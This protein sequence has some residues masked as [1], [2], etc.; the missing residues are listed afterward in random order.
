MIRRPHV[1]I[2]CLLILSSLGAHAQDAPPESFQSRPYWEVLIGPFALHWSNESEHQ[3]VY[4]LGIERSLPGAPTWS[5]GDATIWG[6]SAFN[7]SFGQPSAYLYYGYRWDNLFSN[8]AIYVKLSGGIIYGYKD[9]Y[10][11]KVPFNHNG[12][13]L[14]IIPAVGYRM[15]PRDAIQIGVLGTAGLIFTYNRRF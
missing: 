4:L 10:E 14:A 1:G 11:N 15:T 5:A 9:E 7:N 13:G 12:F 6:F 2:T 8:P 3:H